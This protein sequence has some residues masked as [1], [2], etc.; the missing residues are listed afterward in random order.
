MWIHFPAHPNERLDLRRENRRD[1]LPTRAYL[2]NYELTGGTRI[3][4]VAISSLVLFVHPLDKA[5]YQVQIH[6]AGILRGDFGGEP[7][8]GIRGR[9]ALALESKRA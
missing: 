6:P 4:C 9:Y 8:A 2:T 5:L 1:R 3:L 7:F